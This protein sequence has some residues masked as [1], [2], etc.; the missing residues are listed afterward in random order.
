MKHFKSLIAGIF[1]MF[2]ATEP[3]PYPDLAGGF[4]RDKT[5]LR[6]DARQVNRMVNKACA[7]QTQ[8][9]EERVE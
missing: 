1:A 4:T 7:K 9:L 3:R 2:S 8:A 6:R 5:R